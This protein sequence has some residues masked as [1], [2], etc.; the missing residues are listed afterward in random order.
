MRSLCPATEK[1][2]SGSVRLLV[3]FLRCVAADQANE[4]RLLPGGRL[5]RSIKPRIGRLPRA[6]KGGNDLGSGELGKLF[7]KGHGQTI[8]GKEMYAMQKII[9]ASCLQCGQSSAVNQPRINHEP[10][11]K[12]HQLQCPPTDRN[13]QKQYPQQSRPLVRL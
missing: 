2:R 12:K 9:L 3:R 13:Y 8:P 10:R 7:G 4:K 1:L 6:S 11:R 5:A